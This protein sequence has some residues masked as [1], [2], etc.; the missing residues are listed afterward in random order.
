MTDNFDQVLWR[1]KLGYSDGTRGQAD[2][3][4][5]IRPA[6]FGAATFIYD[7]IEGKPV[8]TDVAGLAGEVLG[9]QTVPRAEAWAAT[10]LL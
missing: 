10:V 1:S 8:I 3:P 9:E 2:I 7:L 5:S 6:A 4:M